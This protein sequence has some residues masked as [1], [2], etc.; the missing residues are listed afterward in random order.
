ME[1]LEEGDGVAR[2]DDDGRVVFVETMEAY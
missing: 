1:S 2:V